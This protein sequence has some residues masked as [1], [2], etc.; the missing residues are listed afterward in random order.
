[1]FLATHNWHTVGPLNI[2]LVEDYKCS[3]K[4][5]QPFLNPVKPP[6]AGKNGKYHKDTTSVGDTYRNECLALSLTA[7]WFA[8]VLSA[9]Q[10]SISSRS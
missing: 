10:L 6:K 4:R 8:G 2:S 7:V 3:N 1:M 9:G 5:L